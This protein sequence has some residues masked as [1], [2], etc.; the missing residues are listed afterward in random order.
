EALLALLDANGAQ[1]VPTAAA[2]LRHLDDVMERDGLQFR[3]VGPDLA[4]A[5]FAALQGLGADTPL[6][7]TPEEQALLQALHEGVA[8]ADALR[9]D[10]PQEEP[11]PATQT[12]AQLRQAS[13]LAMATFETVLARFTDPTRLNDPNLLPYLNVSMTFIERLTRH[14][15]AGR[16]IME[17][18]PWRKLA[19]ALNRMV[20]QDA[21]YVA[22]PTPPAPAPARHADSGGW[23]QGLTGRLERA[24]PSVPP[25][26]LPGRR[27]V[28]PVSHLAEDFKMRGMAWADDAVLGF[29]P[30]TEAET[31][32]PVAPDNAD[33]DQAR[34][35]RILTS[36]MRIAAAAPW[37][38]FD[39]ASQTFLG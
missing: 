8:L 34:R 4:I 5:T 38:E 28:A 16:T 32:A 22:R 35:V 31:E 23:V 13:S 9:A 10:E 19:V 33:T 11:T 2:F 6:L 29:S 12:A 14:E 25:L 27:E 26:S 36:A 1:R 15:G 30:N 37:L 7:K 24:A 20:R 3:S 17:R 18:L 39:H 21:E